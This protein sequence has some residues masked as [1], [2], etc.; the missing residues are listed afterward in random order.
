[1]VLGPVA[2]VLLDYDNKVISRRAYGGDPEIVG[3]F[4]AQAVNGYKRAGLIPVLKHF[5]G[6]GGVAGDT[7]RMLPVDEASRQNLKDSICRHSAAG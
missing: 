4:V 5:P 1:M 7:H 2:D 6:H 3:Q